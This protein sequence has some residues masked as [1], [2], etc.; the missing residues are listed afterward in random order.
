MTDDIALPVSADRLLGNR[1]TLLQPQGGYRAAIDPVLLAAAVPAVAGE[2]VLDLGCGVGTAGLCLAVRVPGIHILGLDIQD[3]LIA[4][5][6][7]NAVANGRQSLVTFAVGDVLDFDGR[8]FDHVLVN[9]PYLARDK[10]SISPNPI[11]AMANVEGDARLAD[12]VA[13]AISAVRPGGSVTF[14]HR[15]DRSDELRGLMQEGL[16]DLKLLKLLPRVDAAPKR[17]IVQGSKGAAEAFH[18]LRPW[19]LHE[20]DGRFTAATD[21]VLRHAAALP[22]QDLPL[23]DGS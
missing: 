3:E 8:D 20:S 16:G 14:I 21:G 2:R 23:T 19:V 7:R 9:P 18:E 17:V 10:A 5:A 4:L 6:K 22:L 1:L 15:A 11:K 13:A 12:W